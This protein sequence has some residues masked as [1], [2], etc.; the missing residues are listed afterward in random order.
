[1]SV[2]SMTY[3]CRWSIS[4]LANVVN[5]LLMLSV[6]SISLLANDVSH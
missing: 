1:M 2:H 6:W 4:L 5:D 3:Q